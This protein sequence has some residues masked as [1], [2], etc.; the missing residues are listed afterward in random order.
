MAK[1]V[2]GFVVGVCVTVVV[3]YVL[4]YFWIYPQVTNDAYSLG[5]FHEAVNIGYKIPGAL[6]ADVDPNERMEPFLGGKM[7][8]VVIVTRNGVKTLRLC[9]DESKPKPTPSDLTN[10]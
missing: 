5:R 1:L 8:S 7:E 6:D 3:G 9:C 2:I 4:G 10:R